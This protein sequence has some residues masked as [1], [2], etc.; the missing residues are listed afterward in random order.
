[1]DSQFLS[2]AEDAKKI[3]ESLGPEIIEVQDL[4]SGFIKTG[5][6]LEYEELF[7]IKILGDDEEL[8]KFSKEEI[9]LANGL[10]SIP[11]N[12]LRKKLSSKLFFTEYGKM[13]D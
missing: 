13:T 12:N 1:M 7:G 8:L 2:L 10:G 5:K 9:L 11:G 3:C 6:Y 4:T